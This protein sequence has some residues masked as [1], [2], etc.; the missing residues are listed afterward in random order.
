ML[1][2]MLTIVAAVQER[3]PE[4]QIEYYGNPMYWYEWKTEQKI[5]GRI[6]CFPLYCS[7]CSSAQG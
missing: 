1:I 4:L 2:D 3:Y 7:C 6:C 5:R